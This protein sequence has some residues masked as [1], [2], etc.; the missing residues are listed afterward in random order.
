[1]PGLAALKMWSFRDGSRTLVV[2]G[3][4]SEPELPPATDGNSPDG[5]SPAAAGSSLSQK[6]GCWWL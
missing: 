2:P 5:S 6:A 3:G 4:G 1:M